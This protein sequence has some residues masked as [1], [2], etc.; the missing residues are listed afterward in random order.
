MHYSSS[1]SGADFLKTSQFSSLNLSNQDFTVE[2]WMKYVSLS[3][4][5]STYFQSE[6]LS[7][8]TFGEP[9]PGYVFYMIGSTATNITNI[10]AI[11]ANSP[12]TDGSTCIYTFP[13]NPIG[14]WHNY[15]FS[16]KGSNM[17]LFVDGILVN[18][19]STAGFTISNNA[20]NF[21]LGNPLS[22][23]V[24]HPSESFMSNLRITRGFARY[25]ANYTLLD[26]PFP[27][28]GG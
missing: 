8:C 16:R 4:Q 9:W 23:S 19:V 6:I 13:T 5:S 12:T 11:I 21:M 18:Q 17:Y 22:V 2:V 15:C 3:F 1:S 24:G 27:L 26:S 20:D 25:T 14:V 7:T 10:S 28:L